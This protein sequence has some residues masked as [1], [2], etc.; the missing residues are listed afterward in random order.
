MS[1]A[2]MGR[3]QAATEYLMMMGLALLI[4]VPLWFFVNDSVGKTRQELQFSY[5]KVA[6]NKIRD[7]A[8][9]VYIQGP[10]ARIYMELQF[11]D[12]IHSATVGGR[13]ILI[14]MPTPSGFTDVYSVTIGDVQGSLPTRAGLVRILVKSE[15]NYVNVTDGG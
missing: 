12:N 11:P 14:R 10:P 1:K 4:V 15:G 6:V 3:A 7:A 9:V 5:A 2:C 8:D 13:E